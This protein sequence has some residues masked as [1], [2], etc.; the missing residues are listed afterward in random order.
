MCTHSNWQ[1]GREEAASAA[2]RCCPVPSWEPRG[3]TGTEFPPPGDTP[4]A[5]PL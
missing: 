2:P 3:G 5:L 4:A 1:E